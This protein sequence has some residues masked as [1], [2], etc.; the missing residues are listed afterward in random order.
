M[1][2]KYLSQIAADNV[3]RIIKESACKTQEGFASS[4]GAE[5]RTVSRWLNGGIHNLDTLQEIAEFFNV[6]V[7]SLLQEQ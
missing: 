5:L 1:N 6:D 3:R 2:S 7:L 4:F